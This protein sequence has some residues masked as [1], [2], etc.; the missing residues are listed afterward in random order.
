M[1]VVYIFEL[2]NSDDEECYSKLISCLGTGWENKK[3]ILSSKI[4]NLIQLLVSIISLY[5]QRFIEFFIKKTTFKEFE[6][7]CEQIHRK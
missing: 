2:F 6:E 4:S 3:L 1:T 5:S 7:I